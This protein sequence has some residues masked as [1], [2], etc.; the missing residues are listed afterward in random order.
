MGWFAAT[1]V[2]SKMT[3]LCCCLHIYSHEI[4]LHKKNEIPLFS[5]NHIE[6]DFHLENEIS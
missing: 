6:H 3:E 5:L 4:D 2:E 1:L